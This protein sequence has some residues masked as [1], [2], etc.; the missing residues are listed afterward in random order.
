MTPPIDSAAGPGRASRSL[1]GRAVGPL[2]SLVCVV[3][4]V[5]WLS[6]QPAPTFPTSPEA[7]ILLVLA[8]GLTLVLAILRGWRW[9]RILRPV[10]VE[11]PRYE[12]YFLTFVGY[13]GNT[14]LPAR[15]G[16]VMRVGILGKRGAEWKTVAGTLIPERLLDVLA[17]ALALVA[18]SLSGSAR[19]RL[20][21]LPAVLA[22]AGIVGIAVVVLGYHE[23]RVRGRLESVADKIRPFTRST[24]TLIGPLGGVLLVFSLGLW[25]LEGLVLW[26]VVE[27]AWGTIPFYAASFVVVL[28]SLATAIPSAPGF[29]G[30]FDAAV[31][32]GLHAAGVPADE[33]FAVA[34]LYRVV[35]FTPVTVVGVVILALRYGGLSNLRPG[36]FPTE[37]EVSSS[38]DA[39]VAAGDQSAEPDAQATAQAGG[40][41]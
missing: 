34:V 26:L 17:L 3:A 2:I 33:T 32:F 27:A 35:L 38:V 9:S 12:P 16:D 8:A 10:G 18:L 36:R 15:G 21:T 24:R 7:I 13:M 1:L 4:A 37:G 20:G 25:A 41:S 30:T 6:T 11:T 23:L 31:I 28:A 5:Y 22:M 29:I 19:D 14:V 39:A 40:M